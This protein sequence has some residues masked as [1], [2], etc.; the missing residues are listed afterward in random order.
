M[1]R[2]IIARVMGTLN[3]FALSY[4]TIMVIGVALFSQDVSRV[5]VAEIEQSKET[6]LSK[7]IRSPAAAV[8]VGKI[9]VQSS[10]VYPGRVL[11][12]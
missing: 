7:T 8:Q 5:K 3:R 2:I 1:L 4:A 6:I 11:L 10:E 12:T 9:G